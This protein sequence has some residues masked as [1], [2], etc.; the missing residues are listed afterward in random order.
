MEENKILDFITS[1]YSWEQVVYKIIAWEGL[2]PWDLDITRLSHAFL[3][4]I[5]KLKRMDFK[6]PAKYI[7]IS[8]MLLRM[9]SDHLQY[10]G[11][12]VEGE[13]IDPESLEETEESE[14]VEG[15]EEARS[16]DRDKPHHDSSQPPAKKEDCDRRPHEGPQKRPQDP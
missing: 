6:I 3:Q 12:L 9:K 5:N 13:Y 4:Y 14:I 15:E 11:D 10:L 7:I 1:E 16:D 2:D 8:S